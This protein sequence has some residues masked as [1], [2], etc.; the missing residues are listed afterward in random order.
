VILLDALF[1]PDPGQLIADCQR[2]GAGGCWVYAARRDAA[3]DDAGIGSWTADRVQAMRGAGLHTPAIIVPGNHPGDAGA[4]LDGVLQLG[5]EPIVAFDLEP[6]SLPPGDWLAGAIATT[7]ARG[8]KALRYGDA[9]VLAGYPGGDGDW[10]SHRSDLIVRSGSVLPVPALP[11]GSVA[12]QYVVEVDGGQYDAS[13]V[14]PALFAAERRAVAASISSSEGIMIELPDGDVVHRLFCALDPRYPPDSAT[15]PVHWSLFPG[16]EGEEESGGGRDV[17]L[18]GGIRPGT[19]WAYLRDF[20]GTRRLVVGGIG[21]DG[22]PWR[23]IMNSANQ[24]AGP[25]EDWREMPMG[26][27]VALPRG[28]S[29]TATPNAPSATQAEPSSG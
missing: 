28:V 9:D 27:R 24:D 19:L 26:V 14:D 6:T 1:P 12:W 3:G 16:G 22:G 23:K 7:R 15:F 13:V 11:S 21:L 8:W 17:D 20:Q 29:S 18:G 25:I 2:H 5:L 4:M 10:L